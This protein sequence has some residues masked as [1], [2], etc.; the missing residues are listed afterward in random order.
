MG[1]P[2]RIQAARLRATK[3]WS[4]LRV[5]LW[6]MIPREAPDLP[7]PMAVDKYWRLYYNPARMT[8]W[9]AE[10]MAA[11]LYHE[12]NHLLRDHPL[13]AESMHIAME[14]APQWNFAT[15]AEIND[16]LEDEGVKLPGDY[17]TPET[18][19]QER[20]GMAEVYFRNLPPPDEM[21]DDKM[22]CGS[23]AGGAQR[24][25]EDGDP[26]PDV[27]GVDPGRQL[28][29]KRKVAEDVIEHSAR[30]S[31]PGQWERWAEGIVN[32]K[33]PWTRELSAQVRV[34]CAW[35]AGKTD[36]TYKKM[37][38]RASIFPR[39]IMP[40]MRSPTPSIAVVV[41]TSGSM[42]GT[43]GPRLRKAMGELKGILRAVGVNNGVPV[44]AC[45]AAVHADKSVF[46][47][48]QVQLG[49]GG[50]TDMG[51]GLDHAAKL[52]PRPEIVIVMTDMYTPW[53]QESPPYRTIVVDVAGD[54]GRE[55]WAVPGW[56]TKVISVDDG[57]E[58]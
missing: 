56:V 33:I 8:D 27:P 23:C 9:S 44:I 49:G 54:G 5:C 13:R 45:D 4:Y 41:D 22:D 34:A 10:Q 24:E 51:V 55:D 18:I 42:G 29:I 37:S 12:A 1:T 16:D 15:D 11:V 38:R 26:S 58:T 14:E 30:G 43:A 32:P 6:A 57:D 28:I 25:W 20:G 40:A 53:P 19:K 31:V 50:G 2:D 35:V 17:V 52:K 46:S 48:S 47:V 3:D 21:D 36:Y 39:I 7:A